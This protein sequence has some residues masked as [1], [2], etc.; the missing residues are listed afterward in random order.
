[1]LLKGLAVVIAIVVVL[2]VYVIYD[3]KPFRP[4][5]GV[6]EYPHCPWGNYEYGRPGNKCSTMCDRV[7]GGNVSGL[8]VIKILIG[9]MAWGSGR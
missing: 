4:F 3:T 8:S 9:R 2:I 6:C 5:D 1:M 7:R